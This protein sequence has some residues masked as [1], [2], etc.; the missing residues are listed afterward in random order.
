MKSLSV[1]FLLVLLSISTFAYKDKDG[2]NEDYTDYQCVSCVRTRR[3]FLPCWRGYTLVDGQC[4]NWGMHECFPRPKKGKGKRSVE[5]S[6][7]KEF[8]PRTD[9]KDV[10][11]EDYWGG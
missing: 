7:K 8:G 5:Q 4:C 9:D 10:V 11:G 1:L 3:S 6:D 2:A